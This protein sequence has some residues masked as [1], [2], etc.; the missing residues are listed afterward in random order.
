MAVRPFPGLG[1]VYADHEVERAQCIARGDWPVVRAPIASG[2]STA[3]TPRISAGETRAFAQMWCRAVAPHSS[4]AVAASAST[5]AARA[6]ASNVTVSSWHTRS[7]LVKPKRTF[8]PS[9]LSDVG[10]VGDVGEVSHAGSSE[11]TTW[12][13]ALISGYVLATR[14]AAVAAMLSRS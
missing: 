1:D 2:V 9:H 11:E 8:S 5:L 14:A 6:I 4:L 10:D 13:F 12:I 7:R 3:P